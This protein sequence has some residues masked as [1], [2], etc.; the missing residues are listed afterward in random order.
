MKITLSVAFVSR[1]RQFIHEGKNAHYWWRT[2]H[3]P[4]TLPLFTQQLLII[5]IRDLACTH[6]RMHAHTRLLAVCNLEQSSPYSWSWPRTRGRRAPA[7]GS[8]VE[9]DGTVEGSEGGAG[10]WSFVRNAVSQTHSPH[11]VRGFSNGI[12]HINPAHSR[13]CSTA[14]K[15]RRCCSADTKVSSTSTLKQT[16][17]LCVHAEL[18]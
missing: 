2:P 5:V 6:T 9:Q 13:R 12:T 8:P 15:P 3:I 4:D 11:L 17:V 16:P 7:V 1:W 18:R 10:S 14:I